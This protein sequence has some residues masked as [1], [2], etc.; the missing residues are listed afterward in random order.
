MYHSYRSFYVNFDDAFIR[1]SFTFIAYQFL[2]RCHCAWC[3]RVCA[4]NILILSYAA[5][6][7]RKNQVNILCVSFM[8]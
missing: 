7:Q 1:L 8:E 4:H 3:V 6:L 2:L 5:A